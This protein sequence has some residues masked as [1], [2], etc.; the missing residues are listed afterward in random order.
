MPFRIGKDNIYMQMRREL[1]AAQ[2]ALDFERN[3]KP[4]LTIFAQRLGTA[5][6]V[7]LAS[8]AY[9]D[10]PEFAKIT[11]AWVATEAPTA[12]YIYKQQLPK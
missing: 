4:M 10:W 12:A 5:L 11:F 7:Q 9:E 8:K 3:T 2:A 1:E 6:L